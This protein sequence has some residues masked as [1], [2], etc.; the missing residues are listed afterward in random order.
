[1]NVANRVLFNSFILVFKG[2]LSI[3]LI[4][5]TTRITLE[6]LGELDYGIYALLG[7]LMILLSFIGDAMTTST[8]RFLS[9][10]VE[11]NKTFLQRVFASSLLLHILMALFFLLL[12]IGC[13][14]IFF[15]Y[16]LNIDPARMYAAKVVYFVMALSVVFTV[17]SIP[18][19]ALMNS[20]ENMLYISIFSLL[21]II[22][23]L[24]LALSIPFF[25]G[26][27]LIEYSIYMGCVSVVVVFIHIFYCKSKYEECTFRLFHF[28]DKS[29]TKKLFSFSS[30][31]LFETMG[32]IT[33]AQGTP[34]VLNRY[35]GSTINTAY[36]VS[37]Q[38]V[39]QLSFFAVT[40]QRVFTPQIT[41]S[42][43][44]QDRLRAISLAKIA[45]KFSYFLIAFVSIPFIFEME[46]IL[47]LWLVKTPQYA[48]SFCSLAIIGG[49]IAQTTIGIQT[50][51]FASGRIVLFQ[52]VMGV[53]FFLNLPFSFLL[54]S[55]GLPPY[56]IYW[57]FI[58]LEII[59]CIF[60]ILY[61]RKYLN[62]DVSDYLK[63]VYWPILI[64]TL[65]SCLV[66]YFIVS[67]LTLPHRFVY[68]FVCS[69]FI[70][71]VS[72]YFTGISKYE[73]DILKG[74]ISQAKAKFKNVK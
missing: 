4:L 74:F 18:F 20:H 48:I 24:A 34:I 15:Y 65:M 73:K 7:G 21:E 13:Y 25:Q 28:F 2:F 52:I 66:S 19:K 58:T 71:I 54:I 17:I 5:Y 49:M 53:L 37:V 67:N 59:S 42:E 57:A 31:S 36:S 45:S 29:I 6:E 51:V 35:Y 55:Q 9:Y 8:Q 43:G 12:L 14:F 46:A 47:G 41:K 10:Y 39:G 56:S 27:K 44:R 68:T 3:G 64:P 69:V 16:I 50:V 26:D 40:L 32:W 23:K 60:R 11:G 22:L 38:I 30:W 72:C 63:S 61:A 70:F 1:M 62:L 33:R